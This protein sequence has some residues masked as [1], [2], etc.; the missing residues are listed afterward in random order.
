MDYRK[1]HIIILTWNNWEVT[2]ACLESVTR[3]AY[4][5]FEIVVVDNG[6]EDGTP[7][8]IRENYPVVSLIENS[9]NLG[10]AAGC[11]V[12]L[13]YA[14]QNES[15]YVFLL[16][17]D[18]VVPPDLVDVLIAEAEAL[19]RLGILAPMLR[20]GDNPEQLWFT[21]SRR[22]P[23]TLESVDFGPLGP[24]RHSQPDVRHPVDYIFGTAMLI[25]A[26]AL[27]EIGLFD[28]AFFMYYEDM[29]L[30]L[31]MQA[32]HYNLYYTPAA[33][34]THQVSAS[35]EKHSAFRYFHKARSSVLFFRKHAG[36]VRAILIVIPYRTASTLR[37]LGRLALQK[38]WAALRAYV[39]G[40]VSG[41]RTTE[42]STFI[43]LFLIQ[44]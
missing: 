26:A 19:P 22:H 29:D 13:R 27:R 38:E 42:S 37:T 6:S 33:S 36:W 30:C 16:N 1:V 20:Y 35:T 34:L 43:P 9:R 7:D 23:L 3:L 5:D 10:F 28:E 25:P 39:R 4:P 18:T 40:L 44:L 21:G 15:D 8:R 17:N 2:V 14:L 24:R 41:L 32:A 11:N 12:G 31:R